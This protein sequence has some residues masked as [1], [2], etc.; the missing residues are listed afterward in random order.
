MASISRDKFGRRRILFTASDGK[1]KTIRLGKIPQRI[2]DSVKIKIESI[3]ASKVSGCPMDNETAQ[4]IADL[5]DDLANRL[6]VVGLI[7]QRERATLQAFLSGY[8]KGRHDVKPASKTVWEQ[9]KKSLVEYF[10]AE[11]PVQEITHAGCEDYKQT[12]IS[13]G[14]ASYTVRKRLQCAKMFF[15]AMVKRSLIRVNPFNGIHVTAVM[16]ES[17]N[18]FVPCEDIEKV[19]EAAPDSEWRAIIA[20]SRFAGLRC[21][22]EVL[23]LKW[24]HIDWHKERITVISPKTAHHPGQGQRVIPLFPELIKPL[25]EVFETTPI[26]AVHV[27]TRH[28]AQAESPGGWRNSNLR[29]TFEKIIR[30][31]GLV[32]W[33]R[34]FHA[35][36]ASFETDLVERF[37]VQ[38]VAAWLGNSPKIALKHYLRVLPEHFDKAVKGG[39]RVAQK[40]AQQG[41]VLARKGSQAKSGNPI[42]AERYGTLRYCTCVKA[43][44]EGFEPPVD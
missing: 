16:D 7:P 14:L 40:A 32:P 15:T 31:A 19:L 37:P 42:N 29:T 24:E 3:L 38:T 43:D 10:G 17:R 5:P 2:A 8:I 1:R 12:L 34:L 41:A 22:S 13:S 18:V 26:G 25:Q 33:P 20:L 27:I 21:P 35:M 6:A 36:R 23:S 28:R 11:T 44:G 9:G 39:N 30:R 4:W